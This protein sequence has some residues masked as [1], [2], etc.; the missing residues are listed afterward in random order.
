[1]SFCDYVNDYRVRY[2]ETILTSSEFLTHSIEELSLNSGFSNTSSFYRAF[3]KKNGI[4]PGKYR[5]EKRKIS[6]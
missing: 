5:E 6:S 2:S 1:M 4:P 3:V